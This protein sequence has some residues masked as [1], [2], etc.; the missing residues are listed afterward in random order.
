MKGNPKL[1]RKAKSRLI[2]DFSDIDN[3]LLNRLI[4]LA[5]IVDFTKIYVLRRISVMEKGEVFGELALRSS[6]DV[7]L[8]TIRIVEDSV[9]T[10]LDR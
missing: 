5:D 6:N 1:L 8:A 9:L 4:R 2:C 7:R 10:Y 3:Q